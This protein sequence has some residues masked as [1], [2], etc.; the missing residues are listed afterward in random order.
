MVSVPL[1]LLIGL[2]GS[3]KTTWAKGFVTQFSAY[4]LVSTDAIRQQLYG[5]EAIQG[6]W[7]VIWRTVLEQWQAGIRAIHQGDCQGVIYD[8]TNARRRY[9]R[10]ILVTARQLGFTTLIGCWFDT[11]LAICLQR[12]R[13]RPRQ[14]PEAI[15]YRMHRQLVGACPDRQEGLD[16]LFRLTTTP[17]VAPTPWK[18]QG[19]R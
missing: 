5:D 16:E 4:Q 8:A 19:V 13:Q 1:I 14:V 2:P 10:D 12:N 9:R 18:S 3:G 11:P 15:L 7:L 6:D 17:W